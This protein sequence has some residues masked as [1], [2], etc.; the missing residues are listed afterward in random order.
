VSNGEA[1]F[2]QDYQ[3]IY[4]RFVP[5]LEKSFDFNGVTVLSRDGFDCHF[6]A[7]ERNATLHGALPDNCCCDL[8][9]CQLQPTCGHTEAACVPK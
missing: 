1:D 9:A 4:G 7:G 5:F 3:N 2:I 8:P 6:M